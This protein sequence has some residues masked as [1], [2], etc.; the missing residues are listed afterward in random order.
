MKADA[1]NQHRYAIILA[2]G[3]GTRL[4]EITRRI[5]GD[6]IPK[7]FC[8]VIG[9]TSL[10]EQTRLRVALAVDKNRILTVFNRAHERITAI[11]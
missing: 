10:L 4:S 1:T 6:S 2:G 9:N 11:C 7:Q 5:S 8:P 3:D